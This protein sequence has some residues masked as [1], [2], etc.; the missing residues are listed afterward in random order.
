MHPPRF[1]KKGNEDWKPGDT[2]VQ[3]ELAETLKRIRDNGRKGFYSG[4]T[5]KNIAN[6]MKRG[7]GIISPEDLQ[8]YRSKWRKPIVG[9]Y[10][11]YKVISMPPPSSGG[12]A[13][14][15]LLHMV[16]NYPVRDY[17]F[18][19]D[20][21]IHL[22][23]EAEK[24]VYADRAQ[25]LG[26]PDFVSVPV[27]KLLDSL[28]IISRMKDFNPEQAKPSS[29][30]WYG[31]ISSHER[32]QTTHFS[33][34]DRWKNA[35]AVTTTLNGA[36][37]S[38]ILV[39]GSGFLL[40]NEMDD[41]SAK[42]GVPNM[43]G[44]VG[45]EANS[46]APG[47]RMLSSMTPTIIEKDGKLF[48]V[49]GT[50]GGSTIITTVFQTVLNVVEYGMTMQEA[51][52]AKKFHCQW[53]PDTIFVEMNAIDSVTRTQLEKRGQ[54]VVTTGS[55]GRTDA[56]LILPDGKLEGAADH[57]GDDDAIGY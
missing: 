47:K 5:A 18:N 49:V 37:G 52:S 4:K 19:S 3:K 27:K 57:R 23:A 24:R 56:I 51:V 40:N 15:Q 55:I 30:I 48:M 22:F 46:I 21:S 14:V 10:K 44:L 1:V 17:G 41:F 53:R 38:Y 12:I 42:P 11:G 35:V 33:I 29:E 6:T 32:V 16:E 26:D 50:P 13:L 43:Y 8:N 25:Y 31:N 28:Y 34:V 9:W 54:H 7:G 39:P 45:A 20:R 2:L 36:F